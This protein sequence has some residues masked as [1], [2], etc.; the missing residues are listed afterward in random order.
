[1]LNETFD[2]NSTKLCPIMSLDMGML[3]VIVDSWTE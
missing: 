2:S 3:A 1:M